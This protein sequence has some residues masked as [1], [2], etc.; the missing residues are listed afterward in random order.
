[1]DVDKLT[2]AD[3]LNDAADFAA[4]LNGSVTGGEITKGQF[5]T[6][7]NILGGLCGEGLIGRQIAAGAFG[8]S[9]DIDHGYADGISRIMD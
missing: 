2:R 8:S 9:G 7:R 5:V 3:G 6:E 1:M 4:I